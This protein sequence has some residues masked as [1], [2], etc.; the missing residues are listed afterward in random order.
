MCWV[1]NFDVGKALLGRGRFR[2]GVSQEVLITEGRND[3]GG[4]GGLRQA[5][6]VL[7]S[8]METL[9]PPRHSTL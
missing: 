9:P 2:E 6:W 1:A 8:K 3:K 7:L 5:V 4:V